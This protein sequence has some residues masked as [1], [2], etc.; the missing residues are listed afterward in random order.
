M[1]RK[2]EH[3]AG[4]ELRASTEGNAVEVMKFEVDALKEKCAAL[5]NFIAKSRQLN[6]VVFQPSPPPI[7]KKP[8]N[9][10][11]DALEKRIQTLKRE[12]LKQRHM[13]M[14]FKYRYKKELSTKTRDDASKRLF[15]LTPISPKTSETTNAS[16]RKQGYKYRYNEK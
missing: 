4:R 12:L 10:E 3:V 9:A 1:L 11:I 14:A 8:A 13:N 2:F 6:H 16:K 7:R 15:G 5:Q